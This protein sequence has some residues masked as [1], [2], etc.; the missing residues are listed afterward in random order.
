MKKIVCAFIVVS[1]LCGCKKPNQTTQETYVPMQTSKP[2]QETQA[3][4][5]TVEPEIP[6]EE[7]NLQEVVGCVEEDLPMSVTITIQDMVVVFTKDV[8]FHCN[9]TLEVGDMVNI[10]YSGELGDHP[11]AYAVKKNQE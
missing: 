8:N 5:E 4:V 11:V 2:V 1:L 10:T 7:V 3:P 9:D 6:F